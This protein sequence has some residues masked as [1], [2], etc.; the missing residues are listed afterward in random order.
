M[1]GLSTLRYYYPEGSSPEIGAMVCKNGRTT[2]STCGQ[3]TSTDLPQQLDDPPNGNPTLSNVVHIEGMCVLGGDSGSPVTRA[4]QETAA[5][6]ISAG[7]C[8][9]AEYGGVTYGVAEPIGRALNQL[10]VQ[11]YGG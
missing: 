10:G 9:Q 3:V 4:D 7:V 11:I 5:G 6:I 8:G 2:A 1:N